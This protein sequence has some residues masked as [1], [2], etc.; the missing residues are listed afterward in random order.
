MTAFDYETVTWAGG[1]VISPTAWDFLDHSLHLRYV[2]DALRGVS[3]RAVEIGCG[4]GRFIASLAAARPDLE[5]HGCDISAT[6]LRVSNRA[7]V[8]MAR[9]DATSLPYKDGQF[10]AVLMVDVLE[11]LPDLDKGLAEVRRILAP[12]GV[13]HLVFPCEGHP[14]TL[15]GRIDRLQ[16]LK[17]EHAGHIQR[18]GPAPLKKR[19]QANGLSPRTERYSYHLLGQ[20]YD[21]AIYVAMSRGINMHTARQAHVENNPSSA[22]NRLRRYLSSLLYLEARSLSRLPLGMTI[23]VTCA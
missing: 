11:H 20:L 23:H 18:L 14:F 6:A 12:N 22:I 7:Q 16:A 9:G 2:L 3:G 10:A 8:Q 13:F 21:A 1:P 15:L 17:R 19:L 5:A 4:S